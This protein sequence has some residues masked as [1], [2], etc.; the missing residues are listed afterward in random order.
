MGIRGLTELSPPPIPDGFLQRWCE[1]LAESSESPPGAFLPTGL[2]LLSATVGPRLVMR[3]GVAHEE[4]MNLWILNVGMSALARKT[5]GLAGLR[6]AVGWLRDSDDLIRMINIA[7]ISDAGL[8][9]SLDVVTSDTAKAA[10]ELEDFPTGA[11]KKPIDVP[12]VVRSVPLSWI[13]TFNEVSPIW[14]EDGKGY[15][16][17]AQRALLA[18]YDGELSSNTRATSVPAQECFVTAIGNIPPGVLRDQ[19]TLGMLASG[20]VGR[21]LVVPTP[22]PDDVVSFPMPNGSDPLIRLRGEVDHLMDLARGVQRATVNDLWTEDAKYLRDEWYRGHIERLKGRGHDDP[23]ATAG[24]ELF[25]RLQA[26]AVKV[27]TLTAVSRTADGLLALDELRVTSD[28]VHWASQVIDSSIAYVTETLRDAGADASSAVGKTEG[29]ILR[30]LKRAGAIGE[31]TA[32]NY[33]AIADATKGGNISRRDVVMALDGLHQSGDIAIAELENSRI[34]W[35]P[36][37]E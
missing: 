14:M 25:G 33:K 31:T 29:R 37:G 2:A 18:I 16:M 13:A 26:T 30:Y 35:L 32:K 5:S 10:K 19:T 22:A 34:V 7:R 11:K 36:G 27:A 21:W 1:T 3:W 15:A 17:D 28:D 6:K 4:R 8:V 12:L 9:S 20:F 24:A 23:F